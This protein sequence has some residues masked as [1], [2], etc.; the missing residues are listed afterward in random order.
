MCHVL[1][2]SLFALV[3][4]SVA[5]V[6]AFLIGVGPVQAQ[7]KSSREPTTEEYA[8]QFDKDLKEAEDYDPSTRGVVRLFKSWVGLVILALVIAPIVIAFKVGMWFFARASAPSNPQQLAMSDPW[9]R[10]HLA[11]QNGEGTAPPV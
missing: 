5:L 1:P 7:Q 6:V 4:G 9:I 2:R 3:A 11:K 8:R 10:A